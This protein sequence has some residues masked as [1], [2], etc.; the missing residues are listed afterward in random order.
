[1]IKPVTAILAIVLDSVGLY[2]DGQFDWRSGYLYISGINNASISLSIYCLV[3]F[4]MATEERLAPF[5]PFYKFLS[6]KAILFFSF[7]QSC[8]F[9]ALHSA[10]ILD[11]EPGNMA[12]NLVTCAEMVAISYAQSQAFDFRQFLGLA[13]LRN[14][15][16]PDCCLVTALKIIFKTGDVLDDARNTFIK[17]EL[18]ARERETQLDELLRGG[19]AFQWSELPEDEDFTQPTSSL[20]LESEN[21]KNHYRKDEKSSKLKHGRNGKPPLAKIAQKQPENSNGAGA[22]SLF[23]KK[24][25]SDTEVVQMSGYAA[26]LQQ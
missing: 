16:R 13:G 14:A 19:Q 18:E 1:M 7:W 20:D 15:Q 2:H 23:L 22:Q 25:K 6:V 9:Q 24:R 3:L 21:H 11:R 4:Y 12:L 5:E 17:D 8:F 26:A 10:E